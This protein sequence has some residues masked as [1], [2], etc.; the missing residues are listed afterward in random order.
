MN[1]PRVHEVMHDSVFVRNGKSY[2]AISSEPITGAQEIIT[3]LNAQTSLDINLCHVPWFVYISHSH[4]LSTLPSVEKRVFPL[5][6]T[7]LSLPD[8]HPL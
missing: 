7:Q 8:H 6:A 3:T 5:I 4:T 2:D 1:K